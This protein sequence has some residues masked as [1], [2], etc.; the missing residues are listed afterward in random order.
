VLF[1]SKRQSR[2]VGLGVSTSGRTE[3][4]IAV[5]R[6]I[7]MQRSET[8]MPITRNDQSPSALVISPVVAHLVSVDQLDEILRALVESTT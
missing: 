3:G 2:T 1:T 5:P 6:E 4:V 7:S 8:E